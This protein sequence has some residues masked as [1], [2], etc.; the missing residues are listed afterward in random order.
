MVKEFLS[1]RGATFKEKDVSVDQAAAQEMVSKTGQRAVPVTIINGETI[2]GFDRPRL[3]DAL[4]RHQSTSHP[5]FGI[6]VADAGKITARQGTGITLGAYVGKV[7]EDSAAGKIGLLPDDII[8]EF[9]KQ[10][11]ANSKALEQALSKLK[12]GSHVAVLFLRDN[13]EM[14][15]DGVY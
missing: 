2:V 1:Q 5:G 11:I 14:R 7:K 9:N 6:S 10:T 4:K 3:E 8:I 13:R 15:A 12:V